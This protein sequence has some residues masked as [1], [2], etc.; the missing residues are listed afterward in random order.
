MSSSHS[1]SRR[2]LLRLGVQL[3][4]VSIAGGLIAACGDRATLCS[5]P[6]ELTF[7][8]NSI[9]EANNYTEKSQHSDKNCLNCS[10]FKTGQGQSPDCGQCELFNGPAAS[11]GYCDSW[12]EIET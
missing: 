8:E 3:P 6:D 9:R 1:H 4:A 7:S 5:N 2:A 11:D 10:F 12:S